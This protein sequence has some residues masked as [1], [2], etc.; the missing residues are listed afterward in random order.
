MTAELLGEGPA[1]PEAIVVEWLQP[2]RRAANT[3]RP[4]D[5]LPMNVVLKVAG[6]ECHEESYSDPVV[7]VDTLCAASAG[8]DAASDESNK[9]HRRMLLLARYL[10]DF[11]L[12]YIKV[13]QSPHRLDYGD[14][15]IIRYVAMYQLGQSYE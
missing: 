2:L 5:P 9:T 11:N 4:G 13:F 3:R 15:Q 7:R 12:D 10:E 14:E 8:E 6:T 1:D